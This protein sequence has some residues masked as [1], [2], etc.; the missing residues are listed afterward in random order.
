MNTNFEVIGFLLLRIKP[1]STAPEAD[2]VI[3]RRSELLEFDAI[4]LYS[5]L[6]YSFSWTYF[7]TS[8]SKYSDYIIVIHVSGKPFF[9]GDSSLDQ[10]NLMLNSVAVTPMCWDS[11]VG[12][13][14]TDRRC[15]PD[16]SMYETRDNGGHPNFPLRDALPQASL[17]GRF[18][19]EYVE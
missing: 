13:G 10:I 18:V 8:S 4:G 14:C 16:P 19:I 9:N 7:I 15:C 6:N 11:V 17:M 5:R 1:E 3:T 2:A 12:G